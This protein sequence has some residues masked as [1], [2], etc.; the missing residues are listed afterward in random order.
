MLRHNTLNLGHGSV[1][2]LYISYLLV[3]AHGFHAANP[4]RNNTPLPRRKLLEKDNS[5]SC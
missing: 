4:N 5:A 1:R 2:M 3:I